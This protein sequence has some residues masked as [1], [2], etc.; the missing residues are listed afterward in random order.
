MTVGVV[1]GLPRETDCFHV[2]PEA[3]RRFKTFAGIGPARAA[4][5]ARALVENGAQALMS[6]GV[7]GGLS[8][9]APAGMVVLAT[10]V[11]ADDINYEASKSWRQEIRTQIGSSVP[12]TE[13]AIAGSD[14]MVGSPEGKRA[15]YR[16]TG[17]IAC[18]MESHAVA[19]IA[20]ELNIPFCVVRAIS[21]PEDRVVPKWVLRCLTPAGDVRV[22]ALVWQ[23]ARRPFAW[24][25]VIGLA[26]DSRKAFDGLRGVAGR[27]GPGLGFKLGLSEL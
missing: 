6:F 7:A 9:E 8:T 4:D 20:A 5:G 11:V 23:A 15:M 21:D 10:N 24:R 26:G 22:G 13:A 18:D 17:A 1:S 19:K 27:L 3:D 14:R 16:D 12:V 2:I 25:N